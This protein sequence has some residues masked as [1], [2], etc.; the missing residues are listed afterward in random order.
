[1]FGFG[2]EQ[3]T[4]TQRERLVCYFTSHTK[5]L[6]CLP[7]RRDFPLGQARISLQLP[8][9]HVIDYVLHGLDKYLT[10]NGST[11]L[12]SAHFISISKQ[13]TK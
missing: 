13:L 12:L 6:S 10:P 2:C 9:N 11:C 1:M 8:C 5:L 4:F 3:L 7:Q